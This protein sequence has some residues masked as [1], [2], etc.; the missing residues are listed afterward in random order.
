MSCSR[1]RGVCVMEGRVRV[2]EAS[3]PA[4]AI[5]VPAGMRRIVQPGFAS[6]TQ[7]ILDQSVHRLHHQRDVAGPLLG[8]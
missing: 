3:A 6:E 5:D 8:R 7:P 1:D 2:G 4:S